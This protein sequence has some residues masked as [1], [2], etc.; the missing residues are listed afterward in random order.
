M[1][2]LPR[3]NDDP[4][5]DAIE[6]PGPL[7]HN[8]AAGSGFGSPAR[9]FTPGSL[10]TNDSADPHAVASP[11]G[12]GLL[13]QIGQE[14]KAAALG[15]AMNAA[16]QKLGAWL[17]G[18]DDGE[19]AAQPETGAKAPTPK[20]QPPRGD[21]LISIS[22]ILNEARVQVLPFVKP[23]FKHGF[24]TGGVFITPANQLVGTYGDLCRARDSRSEYSRVAAAA[25]RAGGPDGI[26]STPASPA[27]REVQPL[28]PGDRTW[29]AHHVVEKVHLEMYGISG[30]FPEPQH[31]LCVLLP[32]MAHQK[33]INSVLHNGTFPTIAQLVSDYEAAYKL[34]GNYSAGGAGAIQD[35]LMR[36][37]KAVLKL[38]G[39]TW[40]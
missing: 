22:D 12:S 28:P 39:L 13:G 38:G 11:A 40:E 29:E 23:T 19:K 33:R 9:G 35:E 16:Q 18:G 37:V 1:P 2:R 15:G 5:G 36:I 30:L 7:G 14:A 17:G 24:E 10:G 20:P 32:Y 8:D 3:A 34:M 27:S 26:R 31:Q 6:T 21:R 4:F 25:P